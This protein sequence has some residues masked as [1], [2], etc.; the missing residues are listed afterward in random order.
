MGLTK[1]IFRIGR[2]PDDEDQLTEMLAWLC[3]M[4]P[5]VRAAIFKLAGAPVS[6]SDT[7]TVRTQHPIPG[8]CLDA[9]LETDGTA[10]ILESKLLSPYRPD[11]LEKYCRWLTANRPDKRR[12]LLTLTKVEDPWP[13][14]RCPGGRPRDRGRGT[15]LGRR[16]RSA[17]RTGGRPIPPR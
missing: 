13:H 6:D 3:E 17:F 5:E 11:Q 14:G 1:N 2:R 9:L 15:P 7:I 4:V 10:L 16:V 12:C 8:G